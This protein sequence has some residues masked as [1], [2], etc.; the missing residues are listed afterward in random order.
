MALRDTAGMRVL[1]LLHRN[2][3]R[4]ELPEGI[5]AITIAQLTLLHLFRCV[6]RLA[7]I[8]GSAGRG[9]G[10][11]LLWSVGM[12]VRGWRHIRRKGECIW[13]QGRVR[14]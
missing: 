11:S 7:G 6:G 14:H 5:L 3:G 4:V 12:I 1:L 9:S 2:G 10:W 13:R 8:L